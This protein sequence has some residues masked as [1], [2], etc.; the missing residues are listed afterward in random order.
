MDQTYQ[1]DFQKMQEFDACCQNGRFEDMPLSNELLD[2]FDM[3]FYQATTPGC[4]PSPNSSN[5]DLPGSGRQSPFASGY[6]SQPSDGSSGTDSNPSGLHLLQQSHESRTN[7]SS[8]TSNGHPSTNQSFSNASNNS[9]KTLVQQGEPSMTSANST[10]ARQ[11]QTHIA[12]SGG[13]LCIP[14]NSFQN[15]AATASSNDSFEQTTPTGRPMSTHVPIAPKVLNNTSSASVPAEIQASPTLKPQHFVRHPSHLRH[16]IHPQLP[17]FSPF[18]MTASGV[19]T[20]DQVPDTMSLNYGFTDGQ[21]PNVSLSHGDYQNVQH[22]SNRPPFRRIASAHNPSRGSQVLQNHQP[23]QES[24]L[25]TSVTSN[26]GQNPWEA[27]HFQKP[28]YPDPQP[29]FQ[30]QSIRSPYMGHHHLSGS[31]GKSMPSHSPKQYRMQLSDTRDARFMSQEPTNSSFNGSSPMS[32]KRE[33]SSPGSD[34]VVST[35]NFKSQMAPR[36]IQKKRRV[37]QELKSNDDNEVVIDP[38][39]L[40]TADL[41]H[42]SPT[43]HTNVAALVDAMHNTDNV[44]DNLGMQKTWEKVRKA[45]ALRIREVCVDLLN[46]TKQAQQ[47]EG[48][49]LGEKRPINQYS[50]FEKR[51][52]ALCETLTFQKTVCKHLIEPPYSYSVVDDPQYAKD[53]VKNNRRVNYQK[54]EAIRLGREHLGEKGQGK[55]KPMI[56]TK[57]RG[58]AQMEDDQDDEENSGDELLS[59]GETDRSLSVLEP[60][61]ARPNPHTPKRTKPVSRSKYQSIDGVMV[62]TSQSQSTNSNQHHEQKASLEAAYL[63]QGQNLE[64]PFTQGLHQN[65]Y[66]SPQPSEHDRMLHRL[67]ASQQMPTADQHCDFQSSNETGDVFYGDNSTGGSDSEGLGGIG[68]GY[69]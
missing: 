40:Q 58:Q 17:Q 47:Q 64:D 42:L 59:D 38:V 11:S 41:T 10:N 3:D 13:L 54:A 56:K 6:G 16:Q 34:H 55:G 12:P 29:M 67:A 48:T 57:K 37:K 68:Y 50:S 32:V 24:S 35:P 63:L 49:P 15:H 25:R 60:K 22:A 45:K 52:D 23:F 53:R 8:N 66:A 1:Q 51:F 19:Y 33:L 28:Q 30:Q 69:S 46:L 20:T 39:A 43:D 18:D 44:E 62:D 21:A 9:A 27:G 36:E 14:N 5:P 2:C 26:S 65:I 7:T 61:F 4:L 31:P